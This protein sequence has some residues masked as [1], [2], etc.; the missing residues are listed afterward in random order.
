MGVSVNDYLSQQGLQSIQFG[1]VSWPLIA[2]AVLGT[3]LLA[4]AAGVVPA[5]QAARL[6]PREAVA[7]A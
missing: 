5:L 3:S 7:G 1:D 6:A 2:A 4:M